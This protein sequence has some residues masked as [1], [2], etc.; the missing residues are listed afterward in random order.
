MK[1]VFL[2]G[3]TGFLGGELLV[4]LSKKADIEKIYC[5]VRGNSFEEASARLEHVF[6]L[7]SDYF[8]RRKVIPILGNMMDEFLG[9]KLCRM[10]ELADVDVII[11]SA[12]NTSFSRMYDNLVKKVNI[13]GTNQILAWSKTLRILETFVYVGTATICGKDITN[14]T[15]LEDESPNE[16]ASQLVTY[17]YTK[18]IGEINVRKAIPKE[19]LLIVRPSIIM[20]DSRDIIPRSYVIMWAFAAFDLMRIIPM[21]KDIGLDIIPVDYTAA[22]IIK[23]L[24]SDRHFNTYN[25]S[26][27]EKSAT[28]MEQVMTALERNLGSP[29]FKFVEYENVVK[30]K[31]WAKGRLE[32]DDMFIIENVDYLKNIES[33]LGSNGNLR[34]L[35]GALDAYYRFGNLGQVFDNT[36][37]LADT[38]MNAPEPAHY[39]MGR[40][41]HL[42]ANI[43]VLEGAIDP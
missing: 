37:M 24:Y 28:T 10:H 39:Y 32:K 7:H 12:A 38:C 35:L 14:R 1:K 31:R 18:M 40:S 23:L 3:A 26:A 19:K 22:A 30:L 33:R 41:K 13:G 15:V 8:D 21:H 4:M 43:D 16:N 29:Q 42:L 2:T 36:R 11:H 27:G 9:E 5:L 17:S 25:I 6:G 20:G 34:I